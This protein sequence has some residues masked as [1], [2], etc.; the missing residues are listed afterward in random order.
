MARQNLVYNPSFRL[1]DNNNRPLG[2]ESYAGANLYVYTNGDSFYGSEHLVVIKDN[3][4][5]SGVQ[6]QSEISVTQGLEYAAS[7]YVR[8]PVTP[9]PLYP[10][11]E[12][13]NLVLKVVWLNSGGLPVGT[14]LTS[15]IVTISESADWTRLTAV[16]TAPA[17]AV[18]CHI[19]IYQVTAGTEN[20]IFYLDA[21]LFEQASYVG[22]YLDNITQAQEDQKV[23]TALSPRQATTIGG[24][25]LNA[26]IVIGDLVLNTVDEYGVIWVCTDIEGWWGH[27]E[28]EIPDIPRGV[29]D[30]SYDV[31][32]RYQSRQL[33]LRGVFLPQSTSQIVRA[34]D[35]LIAATNLV[36][37]GAWLRTNEDPTGEVPTRAAFVRLSGRPQIQTINARGRTEFTI[38]LKA[39]DPVKYGWNDADDNGLVT[40]DITGLDGEGSVYNYGTADVSGVFEITGPAGVGSTITNNVTGETITL[41]EALRG[42]GAIGNIT[43]A[44]VYNNVATLTTN[45]DHQLVVGDIVTISGVGVPFD[46]GD[47]EA[48]AAPYVTVTAS[49]RTVPYTFSFDLVNANI[50]S[51]SVIGAVALLNDDVLTIDTYARSVA[52]NGDITGHRSKIDTLTDWI[53]LT[54]GENTI[55]FNDDINL[56]SVTNKQFDPE[57]S[58]ATLT[59]DKSH[60]L[61]P[62]ESVEIA[63]A[64]Q[65]ELRFKE[66]SSN[67]ITL[68]TVS[69]HG[70]S[71]GDVVD[72]QTIELSDITNKE[73][74]SNVVT[75]TTAEEGGFAEGDNITV[76]MSV[77]KN[78]LSKTADGTNVTLTTSDNHGFSDNDVVIVALPTTTQI[79][80]KSL[81]ANLATITSP[82]AH[83]YSIG[84]SVTVALPTSATLTNKVISGSTAAVTTSSAHNFSV[85]DR[86]SIALPTTATITGTRSFAGAQTATVTTSESTTTT[87]TLTTDAPHGFLAGQQLF[88]TGVGTRYNGIFTIASV[89]TDTITYASNGEALSSSTLFTPV[90]IV[91]NTTSYLVTLNTSAAHNFSLG[92]TITVNLGITA[93]ATVTNRE[94]TTS[95]CTLTTAAT[96]NFSVGEKISVANVDARYNG[97][98]VIT[99]VDAVAKTISYAFAGAAESSTS[100]SGSATNVTIA[101]GYNGIKVIETIPSSTSLTYYYYGQDDAT[102]STLLGATPVITNNTNTSLNGTVTISSIPSTTQFTYTKVS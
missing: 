90:E 29:E 26:D 33:T 63:L 15:E 34:R 53:K 39:A 92:D 97:T 12:P 64:E 32:G 91:N 2:W 83:N 47:V 82:S 3:V 54:S 60:F 87:C 55:S 86:I 36:R 67:E 43:K 8:V 30:G 78:I 98:H 21:V 85:G 75:L 73:L 44:E 7:A 18:K 13:A 81:T 93:A 1:K 24:M 23:N 100:S 27:A 10:L 46:T 19:R 65:A 68:T 99:A 56:Y 95:V 40:V 96:H 74:T 17:G 52:F 70:F 28:P 38:G 31:I 57:T 41:V 72:V 80:A 71:E 14:E 77:T 35:Q 62:G 101:S 61:V 4:P 25:E 6:T 84:D 66:L 88:V 94:A 102:S 45:E 48:G 58:I 11:T 79:S 37:Q 49:N 50:A 22:G 16:G 51:T 89:T 42:A 5:T 59:T 20:A 76:N 9:L 69:S